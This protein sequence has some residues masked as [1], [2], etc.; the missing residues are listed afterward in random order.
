MTQV[1]RGNA[2]GWNTYKKKNK[3][4]EDGNM[5]THLDKSLVATGQTTIQLLTPRT[6][7]EHNTCR[8]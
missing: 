3:Q 6:I 8:S 5:D 4:I 2:Q 1:L 7:K